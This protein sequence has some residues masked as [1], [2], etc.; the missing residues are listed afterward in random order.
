VLDGE[1]PKTL[2][3]P[4]ENVWN[5]STGKAYM[6]V[7][8]PDQLNVHNHSPTKWGNIIAQKGFFLSACRP[9]QQSHSGPILY[10]YE[11]KTTSPFVINEG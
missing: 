3:N 8:L 6:K 2:C 11:I 10:Y 1:E 5:P 4:A 7:T 9:L